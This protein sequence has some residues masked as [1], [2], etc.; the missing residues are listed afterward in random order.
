MKLLVIM[1]GDKRAR[2]AAAMLLLGIAGS[3][4]A[5]SLARESDWWSAVMLIC[6]AGLGTLFF[7]LFNVL[8]DSEQRARQLAAQMTA[9]QQESERRFRMLVEGVAE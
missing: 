8:G 4:L 9:V 7:A 6:G 2:A 3:L 1:Q 5:V